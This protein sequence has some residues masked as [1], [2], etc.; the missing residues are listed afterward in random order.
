MI[1]FRKAVPE[2]AAALLEIYRPY[3]EHESVTL[4]YDLPSLDE[5]TERIRSISAGFP[6]IVC[7]VDGRIAGY[8]YAH[9][10]KER[11][12]YRVC[13]ELSIYLDNEYRGMGLG[14]K[15]YRL[16]IKL[17]GIMGYKNLYGIVTDPNEGSFALHRSLGF[18][19]TGREH[20]AGLKFGVWHDV[21]LFEKLIG[22]YPEGVLRECPKT[23]DEISD[24][25]ERIL[26]EFKVD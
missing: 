5:F 10:Y 24:E 26:E 16:L 14:T 21:V 8:A 22:E 9:K 6:H 17:L 19:I 20:H 18:E 23:I 4:E 7:E 11:F 25:Y 2:D 13:A 1:S 15:L 3:V 12:G